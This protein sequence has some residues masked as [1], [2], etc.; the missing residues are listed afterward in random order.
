MKRRGNNE[1]S[2]TRRKDGRWQAA[3]TLN[4]RRIYHYS[5]TRQECK[6]WIS[7]TLQQI[8]IGLTYKGARLNLKEYLERWLA[9][10]EPSLRPKTFSQYRQV[11]RAHIIP[12]IGRIKLKD[13]RPD[14]IQGLYNAKKAAG[15]GQYSVRM[16]H[17]VLHRALTQA[18]KWGLIGRNPSDAVNRPKVV[19]PEMKVLNSQQVQVLLSF[20]E[21]TRYE[22]FYYLAVTTGLRMGELMGLQ[23]SDLIWTTGRL[24]IQ[25]QVQ[26]V[27]GQGIQLVPPKTKAGKRVVTLGTVALEKLRMHYNLQHQ[28]R[29]SAAHRWKENDLVFSSTQGTPLE[30][31]TIQKHFKVLLKGA[32]LPKIR[33]HD[34]RHTAATLMLEQGAHPKIVQE[35]LGHS[36]ISHTLDTYSHVL[37]D[38]QGEVAEALDEMLKPIDVKLLSGVKNDREP[39]S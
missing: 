11:C 5:K 10:V 16:I 31:R 28:E 3:V 7:H 32:G 34:L 27:T 14:Q 35:R 36:A 9:T 29:I 12:I 38:M 24:R 13:L 25:R 22:A 39:A 20:V 15:M 1:G 18:L 37:P 4:G 19:H 30:P 8:D 21:G 33:F 17:V 26:R 23:W 6:D 2:I